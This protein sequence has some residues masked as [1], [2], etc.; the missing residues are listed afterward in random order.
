MPPKERQLLESTARS[1]KLQDDVADRLAE[2]EIVLQELFL[3]HEE[4]KLALA[5][6]RIG[7]DR[8][9]SNKAD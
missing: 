7:A 2:I 6:Q 5:R 1:L 3:S 9:I 4:A 8:D